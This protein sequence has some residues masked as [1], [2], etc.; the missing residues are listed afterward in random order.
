MKNKIK[1][2]F[3]VISYF[4]SLLL[5]VDIVKSNGSEIAVR[6][7]IESTRSITYYNGEI[8]WANFDYSRFESTIKEMQDMGANTIWFVLPWIDFHL[9]A[10]PEPQWNEKAVEN[11]NNAITIVQTQGM[12]VMLPLCYLGKGWSPKGIDPNVWTADKDM[13][14]AFGLYAKTLITRLL[15]NGNDNMSFLLYG[16]GCYPSF[17]RTREYQI[18]VK[19]FR[20]WCRDNNDDIN[21]WNSR[22][23]TCYKWDNLLP[24]TGK[25][26]SDKENTQNLLA[27]YWRWSSSIICERHGSLAHEIRGIIG[28]KALIGYH[29]DAIIAKDWG[30][31]VT[32]I[33]KD[34]P[35][36]FLSFAH[37][38]TLHEYGSLDKFVLQT[39]DVITKFK[40]LY[41]EMP[42]GIFET[43][44][45]EQDFDRN[46]QANVISEIAHIAERKDVGINI[47]MW[48]DHITGD[49]CQQTFGLITQNGKKKP[50]YLMLHKIWQKGNN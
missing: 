4:Q 32:P 41:P 24:F 42:L 25:T 40:K 19:S 8:S 23:G 49:K 21:F 20:K 50:A 3:V 38:Y 27:D 48:Q 6:Q 36:Q 31:G 45:C 12:R 28:N 1:V 15:Q 18:T 39:N 44:L 17:H 35:Y 34:N 22:W 11:L 2:L 43:G 13:Y 30:G 9:Q 37:Y 47:W 7:I 29:D 10:L 33:P 46:N 5:A 14:Q 26:A 16:E